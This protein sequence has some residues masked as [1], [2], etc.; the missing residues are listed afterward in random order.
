MTQAGATSGP[1]RGRFLLVLAG[2]AFFVLPMFAAHMVNSARVDHWQDFGFGAGEPPMW[3]SHGVSS[4][5][6]AVRWRANGFDPGRAGAWKK[7]GFIAEDAKDWTDAGFDVGDA[8]EWRRAAF[9]PP[10]AVDWRSAGFSIGEALAWRK[11]A[12]EPADAAEWKQAGRSPIEAAEE[13][14]TGRTR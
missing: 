14:T 11:H 2:A 13:R 3:W 4:R 10:A 12:F 6:D 5:S 8:A 9:D 1:W 7:M